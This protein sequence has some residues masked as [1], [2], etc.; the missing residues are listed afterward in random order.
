MTL[1][2]LRRLAELVAAGAT[3]VGQAPEGSPSLGDDPDE[4]VMLVSRLWGDEAIMSSGRGRVISN[5]DADSALADL[6]VLPSFSY[7]DPADAERMLFVQRT[8][9]EGEIYYL[10]NPVEQARD[11]EARFRATGRKPEIWRADA[12]TMEPMS[13]RL[14]GG[15]TIIPLEVASLDAFFVVFR[16]PSTVTAATV[17]E[18]FDTTVLQIE[19]PW[20]VAFQ[21]DRGAPPA[22]ELAMLTL[23]VNTSIPAS[24][25]FPAWPA[26]PTDLV[27]PRVSMREHRCSSIWAMWLK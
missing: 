3:I 25:I 15:Q 4:F 7:S 13:Y 12:G 10:H 5:R 21:A 14:D 9:A 27:C 23:S 8:L 16:E 26:I 20:Q 19:G 6:G 22:I 11:I 1:P 24:N 18:R 17:P 2:V